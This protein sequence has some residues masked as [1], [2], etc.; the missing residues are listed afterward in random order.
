VS[1][2]PCFAIPLDALWPG[3]RG[4]PI[5]AYVHIRGLGA[6]TGRELAMWLASRN[7]LIDGGLVTAVDATLAPATRAYV[8]S[9]RF[10]AHLVGDDR[11]SPGLTRID[12]P[13]ITLF[14]DAGA[15]A[16]V[17]LGRLL[18]GPPIAIVLEGGRGSGRSTCV[19]ASTERPVVEL[20][21][22]RSHDFAALAR[23]AD[24]GI[25]LPLIANIDQLP[26]EP[27]SG[28]LGELLDSGR[29]PT[30]VAGDQ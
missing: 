7:P 3:R 27:R 6:A 14:D 18:A 10:L 8:A 5:S 17:E 23:E 11:P 4:I 9:P 28:K 12:L 21:A 13:L 26:A 24:L 22:A 15:R 20:D 25:A 2:D 29:S 1:A 16:S 30:V 19:A